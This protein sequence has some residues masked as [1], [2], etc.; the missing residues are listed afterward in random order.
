M[1]VQIATASPSVPSNIFMGTIQGILGFT[2]TQVGVLVDD[3]YASQELV[4]YRRFTDIKE[5]CQLKAN[6]PAIRGGVA[7]VD[8]KIKLLQALDWWVKHLMLRGKIIDLNNFNTDILADAIE[9][10]GIDFEDTRDGKRDLSNPKEFSREKW[11]QWENII[12]KYFT[13]RKKSHGVPLS[14]VIRKDTPSL[15]YIENRDVKIIYKESLSGNMFTGDSQ[16][17]LNITKELTLENYAETWIKDLKCGR[18]E[19]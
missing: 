2:I 15:E 14:Y 1:V 16:K 7:Y 5:W 6:I 13:T 4:L 17:V 8:R 11:S 9:K 12:Y 3:A 18:N 19:I 10:S